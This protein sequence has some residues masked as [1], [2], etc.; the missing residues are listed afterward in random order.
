M[1]PFIHVYHSLT[2]R[3]ENPI[4]RRLRM[5]GII[6]KTHSKTKFRSK[7]QISFCKILRSRHYFR[8]V[9]PKRFY[10]NCNAS[11]LQVFMFISVTK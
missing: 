8:K 3:I 7:N 10:L 9:L 2:V 11:K 1:K 4:M 5:V 6:L